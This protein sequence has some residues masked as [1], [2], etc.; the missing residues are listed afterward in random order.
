M[1]FPTIIVTR[2]I[3]HTVYTYR[4]NTYTTVVDIILIYIPMPSNLDLKK[5]VCTQSAFTQHLQH[6]FTRTIVVYLT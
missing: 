3:D 1:Q 4:D 6:S 2:I 5:T